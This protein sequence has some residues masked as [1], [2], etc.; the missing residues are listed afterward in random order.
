MLQKYEFIKTAAVNSLNTEIAVFFDKLKNAKAGDKFDPDILFPASLA[1][2]V[3]LKVKNKKGIMVNGPLYKKAA[4]F[5]NSYQKLGA[6]KVDVDTAFS[7]MNKIE[8]LFNSKVA[9]NCIDNLPLQIQG[10]AK[11]LFVHLYEHTLT[12]YGIKKHYEAFSKQLNNNWCPF[13]GM[14]QLVDYTHQK[15]DYDHLLAKSIYPF[16][17]V[18]MKNL[19]PM[20]QKCNRTH[21]KKKDLIWDNVK[22][23]KAVNPYKATIDIRVNFDG[24][25]LPSYAGKNG[26]WSIKVTP[27]R[28]E[29]TR[30]DYVFNICDRIKKDY[31]TRGRKPEYQVWLTDYINFQIDNVSKLS[32]IAQVRASLAQYGKKY[33]IDRYRSARYIQ[34]D[35]FKWISANAPSSF[36]S[37]II[38]VINK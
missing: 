34:A 25:K 27:N 20:G 9:R 8:G 19:I 36:I 12:S 32:T 29:V 21:K 7:E 4:A 11:S 24:T 28:E 6:R 31:L 2:K 23:I 5:F 30:W 14:E 15:E 26:V 3:K 18:N 10:K 37:S 17:S 35:F 13:C 33:D 16:A 22:Q 1:T 38:K